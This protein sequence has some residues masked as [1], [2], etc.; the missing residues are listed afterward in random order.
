MAIFS[1]EIESV[2]T[3]S[4]MSVPG[5]PTTITSSK[6]NLPS[7][8]LTDLDF[9]T[10]TLGDWLDIIA[11]ELLS[12]IIVLFSSSRISREMFCVIKLPLTRGLSNSSTI[13]LVRLSFLT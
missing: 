7:E 2:L 6:V 10:V 11:T 8:A 4:R 9:M 13:A 1:L 12:V 5:G 3:L